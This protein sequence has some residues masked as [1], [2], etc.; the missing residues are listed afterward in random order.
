MK[1]LKKSTKIKVKAKNLM[2]QIDTE[3]SGTVK[4]QIFFEILDMLNIK[5][6]VEDK[7]LLKDVFGIS[8]PDGGLVKIHYK[9]A[10]AC[11]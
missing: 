9:S 11:L 10:L 2:K 5:L 8:F 7:T 1:E 3:S 6:T 4:D